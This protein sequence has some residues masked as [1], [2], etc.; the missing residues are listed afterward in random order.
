MVQC[1]GFLHNLGAQKSSMRTFLCRLNLALVRCWNLS[2]LREESVSTNWQP[3]SF[4]YFRALRSRSLRPRPL[5]HPSV[6][7]TTAA[8]PLHS[9]TPPAPP[10]RPGSYPLRPKPQCENACSAR[11]RRDWSELSRRSEDYVREPYWQS[12]CSPLSRSCGDGM[13]HQSENARP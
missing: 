1:R 11:G 2:I 8:T 5:T 13:M 7:A 12:F 9:R 3:Q 4:R 10:W 6:S